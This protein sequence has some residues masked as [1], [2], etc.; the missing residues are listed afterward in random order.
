MSQNS[1]LEFG[2]LS[3]NCRYMVCYF[4]WSWKKHDSFVSNKCGD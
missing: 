4:V 1:W 2:H 3:L